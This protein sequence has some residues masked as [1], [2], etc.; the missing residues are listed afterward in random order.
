MTSDRMKANRLTRL[1]AKPAKQRSMA[2]IKARR[3]PPRMWK[4]PRDIRPEDM[5]PGQVFY[6]DAAPIQMWGPPL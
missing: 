6:V 2:V 3:I 4:T 5:T 1:K